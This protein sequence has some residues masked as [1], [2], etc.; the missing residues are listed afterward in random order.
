M[1]ITEHTMPVEAQTHSEAGII[2]LI[3]ENEQVEHIDTQDPYE[4][5]SEAS[6]F[7]LFSE[8]EPVMKTSRLCEGERC[9]F[10]YRE[11]LLFPETR[12]LQVS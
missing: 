11:G 4:S 9:I 3:A 8:D 7:A 6:D 5:A 10:C 2:G 1:H 12:Q